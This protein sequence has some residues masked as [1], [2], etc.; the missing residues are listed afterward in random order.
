MQT[1]AFIVPLLDEYGRTVGIYSLLPSETAVVEYKGEPYLRYRFRD[2]RQAAIELSRCG[3]LTAFQYESDLFGGKNNALNNT[4][5]LIDINN[6]GIK[7]AIK[8]SAAFRFMAQSSNFSKSEDLAKER[9]RFTE[10]NFKN[11]GGGILLFPN[12]Y[13][14]PKQI[15]SKPYTVDPAERALINT[16]VFNYF[17]VSEDILQNK[18]TPEVF[19]SFYEG[20]IEPFAIQASEVLT[21]MFYTVTEQNIGNAAI[22]TANRLQ[23]MSPADKLNFVKDMADRGFISINEGREVFNLSP[24]PGGDIYPIRGEYYHIDENGNEAGAET[25]TPKDAANEEASE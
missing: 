22:L 14:N 3:I 8:Q 25:E 17:G 20:A 6:Q 5:S 2:G 18:A 23:H 11:D 10:E 13:N 1:T 12:T 21:N 19:A 24:I 15:I 4:L 9:K 16:N 7:E